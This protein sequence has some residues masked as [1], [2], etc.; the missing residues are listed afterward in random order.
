MNHNLR[1]DDS[2]KS[3]L[4]HYV[5]TEMHFHSID[6]SAEEITCSRY[7]LLGIFREIKFKF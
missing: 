1:N 7:I 2:L 4:I 5:H 6:N 3:K